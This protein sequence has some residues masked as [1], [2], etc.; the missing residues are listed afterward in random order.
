[1]FDDHE[2]VAAIDETEEEAK[3]LWLRH[4]T[5][6]GRFE[7]QALGFGVRA[8]RIACGIACGIGGYRAAHAVDVIA[9]KPLATLTLANLAYALMLGF[10]VLVAFWAAFYIAFGPY[11]P[12]KGPADLLSKA[13][14]AVQSRQRVREERQRSAASNAKTWALLTNINVIRLHPWKALAMWLLAVVNIA[15]VLAVVIAAFR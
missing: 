6:S 7:H 12:P 1:M 13:R 10:V 11:T 9:H 4:Q 14:D 8:F 2:Q 15:T 3:R 5:R